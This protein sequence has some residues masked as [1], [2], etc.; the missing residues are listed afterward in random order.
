MTKKTIPKEI[1]MKRQI[2]RYRRQILWLDKL[3]A[4]A[5]D[6]KTKPFNKNAL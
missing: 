6:L 5:G 1:W 4:Y 3:S 2:A